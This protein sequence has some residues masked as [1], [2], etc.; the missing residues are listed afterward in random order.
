[1]SN[2]ITFVSLLLLSLCFISC[3]KQYSCQCATTIQSPGYYPYT[4]SSLQKIDTKTTKK[5]AETI[6]SHSEKQLQKNTINYKNGSETV[7]TSCALK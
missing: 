1:M 5:R 3:K 7:T 6:C 2:K 4:V